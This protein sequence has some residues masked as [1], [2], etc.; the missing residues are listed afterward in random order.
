MGATVDM[1]VLNFIVQEV[2]G[3]Q[4]EF[5]MEVTDKTRADI[6]VHL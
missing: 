5:V 4:P 3:Q 1:N 2:N 6:K